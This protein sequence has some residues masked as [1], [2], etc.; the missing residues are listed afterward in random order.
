LF[1]D[2]FVPDRCDARLLR[3]TDVQA[4]S[5]YHRLV[6]WRAPALRRAVIVMAIGLAVG[7]VLSFVT[8][9]QLAV[10]AGWDAA[11]AFFLGIVWPI[12]IR[13]DG[14]KTSKIASRE[15]ET[16]GEATALIAGGSTASLLGVGFALGLASRSHGTTQVLLIAVAVLTVALSWTT[17]NTVYTLRYAHLDYQAGDDD[18]GVDFGQS[19]R[20]HKPT[21]RDFAYLAFT[22][23]MTY[24]VSDTTVRSSGIRRTVLVHAVLSYVFGV[25]IVA[26]AVNLIA[27]LVT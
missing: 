22:I 4:P 10:I 13:A 18:D 3:M 26:G 17:M 15:D 7:L 5:H 19:E 2:V 24:Q 25:V 14:E 11:M 6:G 9:W 12:I 27:G 20:R 23:G 1:E 8:S 16:H 21:Y